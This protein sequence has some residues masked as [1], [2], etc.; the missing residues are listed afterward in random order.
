MK[1]HVFSRSL[2]LVVGIGWV[3]AT[4]VSACGGSSDNGV[5]SGGTSDASMNDGIGSGDDGPT[6]DG[7]GDGSGSSSGGGDSG[8]TSTTQTVTPNASNL[9]LYEGMVAALDG[10]G[11]TANP[12][13]TIAFAWTVVSAPLGS[14]IVTASLQNA[15][16]AQPSFTTDAVGVYT[17]QMTATVGTTMA[18]KTVTVTAVAAPVFYVYWDA[19]NGTNYQVIGTDGTGQSTLTCNYANTATVAADASFEAVS[20]ALHGMDWWEAPPGTPSR[21]AYMNTSGGHAGLW[22][23]LSTSTCATPPTLRDSHAGMWWDTNC[24]KYSCYDAPPA[25]SQPVFSPDGNRIAYVKQYGDAGSDYT[26]ATIGFDGTNAHSVATGPT[27]FDAGTN[28]NSSPTRPRWQDNTDIGWIEYT[29]NTGWQIRVAPDAN[30]SSPVTFMTCD[31][32]VA[33]RPTQFDFVAGGAVLV[34]AQTVQPDGAL[35]SADLLVLKPNSSNGN[36]C[37]LVRNLTLGSAS[38][39]KAYDFSLSPDKKTVAYL[40]DPSGGDTAVTLYVAAVDGT[41]SPMPVPGAP[42][43]THGAIVGVYEQNTN[44]GP[45]WVAGGSKLTWGNPTAAGNAV[46]VIQANAGDAAGTVTVLAQSTA[47]SVVSAVGNGLPGCSMGFAAGG[48]LAAGVS[49][50]GGFAALLIRRRRRRS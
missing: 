16:T 39:A 44:V 25:F 45:R 37:E 22:A 13:G 48:S 29:G 18:T 38:S 50:I 30:G 12:P 35:G 21:F 47:T 36:A 4:L 28:P 40:N 7:G 27:E 19:T 8:D 20:S 24:G 23:G 11:T 33:P 42:T 1:V 9:T 26:F 5:D 14:A 41:T 43:N 46:A 2:Y 32:G 6:T 31:V 49:S 34:S 3:A 10:T 15:N 17:L